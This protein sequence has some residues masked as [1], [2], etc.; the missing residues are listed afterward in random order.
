MMKKG[1]IFVVNKRTFRPRNNSFYIGRPNVLGN[2]FF[3]KKE[4]DRNEVCE[5]YKIWLYDQMLHNVQVYNMINRMVYF[6][7][8][9]E[10]IYLVCWCAPKRCHG[11]IIKEFIERYS[12]NR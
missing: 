2:P 6:L 5:K 7:N 3:M 1:E 11:D 4:E 9:K 12:K 10:H 8:K